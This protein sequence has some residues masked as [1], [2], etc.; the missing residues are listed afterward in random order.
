MRALVIALAAVLLAPAS[1]SAGRFEELPFET[2]AGGATCV[3]PT[4]APGE[5]VAWAPG[6]ARFIR[7]GASGLSAETTVSLGDSHTCPAAAAQPDGAGVLAVAGSGGLSVALREPGGAWAPPAKLPL[8]SP[9]DDVS[10][11]AT[12]VSD[13]GDAVVMWAEEDSERRGTLTRIRVARR[14]AGAGFGAP[15]TLATLDRPYLDPVLRAGI[16]ADGTAVAAWSHIDSVLR[17]LQT[18]ADVA[19][20]PPDAPFG[21]GRRLT[22][23]L[24]DGVALAVSADGRALVAFGDHGRVRMAEREPGG[25][26]GAPQTLGIG[27]GERLAVALG[28]GSEA[29]VAWG[30]EFAIGITYA[31]RADASGFRPPVELTS[32]GRAHGDP[33]SGAAYSGSA[34]AVAGGGPPGDDDGGDLRAAYASGGRVVLSWAERRERSGLTWTAAHV[35]T[36]SPD[37][38]YATQVAGGPLRDAGSIAPVVLENGV[39]AVAWS[40]NGSLD[41]RLHL[42]AEGAAGLPRPALRVRI[43]RPERTVLRSGQS[44]VVPV[45]CSAACDLRATARG[46]T[47][48]ASLTGAGTAKLQFAGGRY[49]ARLRAARVAVTVLSGPPGA[50]DP[51]HQVIHPRLRR[52]PDPPLPRVRGLTAVRSGSTVDVSWR[53]D[54]SARGVDFVAYSSRK[55]EG[56]PGPARFARGSSRTT[57]TVKLHHVPASHKYVNLQW[58][59]EGRPR[60]RSVRIR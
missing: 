36:V 46:L 26:F 55:R 1:A 53:V 52:I 42:A 6:G 9:A 60:V 2:L 54:R 44:L 47:A 49:V 22:A 16:A 5:L 31:R 10:Q 12:A 33:L 43:G 25:G 29:L 3:R 14:L 19:I 32:G 7:A 37:D 51:Q 13:R 20:A 45:A 11:L 15:Q 34:D 59:R 30:D 50:R 57:F 28:S 40:D 35:A 56:E 4:G 41:G 17:D 18:V 23:E 21:A 38:S 58:A 27:T 8:P 48:S 24:G 39:P